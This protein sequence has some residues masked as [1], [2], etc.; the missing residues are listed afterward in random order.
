VSLCVTLV[1]WLT[2]FTLGSIVRIDAPW[3]SRCTADIFRK[4]S[5]IE[6]AL[7]MP[8]SLISDQTTEQGG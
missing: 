4:D 6:T 3:F 7:K 2:Y 8:D 1:I 5:A